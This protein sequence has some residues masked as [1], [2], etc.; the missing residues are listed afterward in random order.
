[1]FLLLLRSQPAEDEERAPPFL[2]ITFPIISLL[3][4]ALFEP[5]A[6]FCQPVFM[7]FAPC[8]PP[9]P[10]LSPPASGEGALP[11]MSPCGGY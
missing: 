8:G 3:Q 11:S 7:V 5:E 1:M 2:D 9:G 6:Q 10:S 4:P